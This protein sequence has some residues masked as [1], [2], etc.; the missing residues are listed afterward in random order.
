M[1]CGEVRLSSD[2][3]ERE[4]RPKRGRVDEEELEM[5]EG[6]V[7]ASEAE[8]TTPAEFKEAIR[9]GVYRVDPK[10]LAAVMLS[11]PERPLDDDED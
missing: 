9:S 8:P 5:L 11:H 7:E 6:L 4:G 10:R 2:S 3:Q 1:H